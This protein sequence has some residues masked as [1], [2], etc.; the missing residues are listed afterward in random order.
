MPDFFDRLVGR[1]APDAGGP[2]P[3]G[4]PRV[5]PRLPGPFERM[6]A[7]GGDT[8]IRTVHEER[9]AAPPVTG[10]AGPV[11]PPAPTPIGDRRTARPATPGELRLPAAVRE[12]LYDSRLAPRAP[13]ASLLMPPAAPAVRPAE[14]PGPR[15][16]A[17]RDDRGPGP[18]GPANRQAPAPA[19]ALPAA[20]ARPVPAG[21]GPRPAAGRR[22]PA[23]NA[24]PAGSRGG[25]QRPPER[26][27]HVSIGRLEVKAAG[28]AA[29]AQDR[30]GRTDRPRRPAP[31]L[32][33][34]EYLSREEKRS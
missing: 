5:R 13:A 11:P 33:L 2:G 4:P 10:P 31:V 15:T 23:G 32:G 12:Q 27:V 19:A 1:G 29:R 22:S 28:P 6:D 16:A 17:P 18:A 20:P 14:R 3:G 25:G 26:V 7:L 24:D 8:G 30:P 9:T 34:S 21:P